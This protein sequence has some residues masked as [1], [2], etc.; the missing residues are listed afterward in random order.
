MLGHDRCKV[1][2][3]NYDGMHFLPVLKRIVE[4]LEKE[5][6]EYRLPRT[7]AFAKVEVGEILATDLS[8]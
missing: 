1:H 6:A 7:D 8:G 3:K 5:S 4:A 2:E